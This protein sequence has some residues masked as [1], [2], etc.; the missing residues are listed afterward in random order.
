MING[1]S[2]LQRAAMQTVWSIT[3]LAFADTVHSPREEVAVGGSLRA[4]SVR[5][6]SC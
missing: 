1:S 6:K 3:P 5:L 2:P 4:G